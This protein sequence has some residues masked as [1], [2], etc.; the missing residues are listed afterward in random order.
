MCLNCQL[1]IVNRDNSICGNG[2]LRII[3]EFSS[4][5]FGERIGVLVCA[6]S[7]PAPDV[8]YDEGWFPDGVQYS[9]GAERDVFWCFGCLRVGRQGNTIFSPD[10]TQ[11]ISAES[12]R[13]DFDV[14]EELMSLFLLR[15]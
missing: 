9:K 13:P 1:Q 6:S 14:P 12:L 10:K 7:C 8:G 2:S 15:P 11:N 4:L 3:F 5:Y